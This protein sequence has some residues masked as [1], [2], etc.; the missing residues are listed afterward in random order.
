MV[1]GAAQLQPYPPTLKEV[2]GHLKELPGDPLSQL[3]QMQS[4]QVPSGR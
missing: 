2:S 4:V 3:L 1:F